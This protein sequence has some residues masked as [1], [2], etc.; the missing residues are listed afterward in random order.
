MLQQS[1]GVILN[2]IQELAHKSTNNNPE[3]SVHK[4]SL[5]DTAPQPLKTNVPP[6]AMPEC[7]VC[8]LMALYLADQVR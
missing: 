3:C 8:K 6:T 1:T 2:L 7:Q 4:Q 5:S